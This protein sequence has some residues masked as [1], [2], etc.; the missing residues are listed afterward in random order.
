MYVV[1]LSTNNSEEETK[2]SERI[3]SNHQL[4]TMN[5]DEKIRMKHISRET[6]TSS[7]SFLDIYVLPKEDI[8]PTIPAVSFTSSPHN[9]NHQQYDQS[10]DTKTVER[11]SS[12]FNPAST[13]GSTILV[14]KNLIVST[15]EKKPN[16]LLRCFS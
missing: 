2:T 8:N 11:Q 3:Q 7:E 6:S 9:S 5:Q 10:S 4:P 14:W 12:I 13:R 16:P 15:R 1:S